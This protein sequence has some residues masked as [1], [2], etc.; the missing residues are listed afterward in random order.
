[1]IANDYQRAWFILVKEKR[2]KAK[3]QLQKIINIDWELEWC[4]PPFSY[5]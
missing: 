4:P 3:A 1:M 2:H 5:A